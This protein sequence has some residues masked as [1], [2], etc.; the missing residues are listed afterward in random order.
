LNVNEEGEQDSIGVMAANEN[1]SLS[2]EESDPIR[3][4]S[5]LWLIESQGEK[6][7]L[8]PVSDRHFGPWRSPEFEDDKWTYVQGVVGF[9]TRGF[10]GQEFRPQIYSLLHNSSSGAFLRASFEVDLNQLSTVDRLVLRCRIND[11]FIAYLNGNEIVRFNVPEEIQWNSVALSDVRGTAW[12]FREFDISSVISQLKSGTNVLAVHAVNSML[13][14]ASFLIDYELVG[15]REFRGSIQAE[16]ALNYSDP[17]D[18]N[19]VSGS[20]KQSSLRG[21]E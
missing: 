20:M 18:V 21:D 4:D 2:S 12:R 9:D 7:V 14:G 5:D 17:I 10:S 15:R 3:F 1:R 8:I 11:G 19:S 16:E 6:R 13:N